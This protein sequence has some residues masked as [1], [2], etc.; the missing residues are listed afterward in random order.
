MSKDELSKLRKELPEILKVSEIEKV[1]KLT[2]LVILG[3]AHLRNL[4]VHFCDPSQG[5]QGFCASVVSRI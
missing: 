1:A 2:R 5:R 4:S 3:R